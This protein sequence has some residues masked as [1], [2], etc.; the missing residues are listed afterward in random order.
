MYDERTNLGQQVAR[1]IREFFE[2]R[3]FTTVIPRNVRL[4]EAPSHGLPAI[5]YDVEVARRRSLP[6]ARA[7]S[8]RARRRRPAPQVRSHTMVEKRPALGR[9]LTRAHPRHA[10]AGPPAADRAPRRRHRSAAAE[11]VSAAHDDGRRADRGARAID[12]RQ[13]HHPADRRPQ[14]RRAATRSSPANAAGARRSAPACSR[15][16]SSSATSRR[17]SSW[18]WRSSRT[19]SAKI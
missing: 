8:A 13:R 16:R 4:G 10:A 2:E 3:V 17:S 9:G 7:R 12:P 19:S 15:C 5:V 14:G 6:R 18:R 1:D 11:P